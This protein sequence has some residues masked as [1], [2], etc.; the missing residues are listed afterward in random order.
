MFYFTLLSNFIF[1][2][3]KYEKTYDKKRL[4]NKTFSNQFFLLYENELLIGYEKAKKILEKH[5]KENDE[6]ICLEAETNLKL[7]NNHKS[8]VG[9]YIKS[10]KIKINNVYLTKINN[11]VVLLEKI[12]IEDLTSKSYMINTT[13]KNVKNLKPRSVSI[14]P[15]A[16][17]CQAKCSFCF[18]K[19]SAS[20]DIHNKSLDFDLINNLLLKS[21]NNGATRA[22]ITGGGE[23]TMLKDDELLKLIKLMSSHFKTLLMITNSYKYTLMSKDEIYLKLKELKSNGLTRIGVSRH[24]YCLEKNTKLMNLKIESEKILEVYR[25]CENKEELPEIRLICVIQKNGIST[26]SDV[27]KYIKWGKQY[28]IK[29]FCFKELYVSSTNES[30]Y[31]S[32]ENND[33]SYE[34]QIPLKVVID[35]CK[36]KNL[37][38]KG[39]LPWGTPVYGNDDLSIACYT[40]PSIGWEL[41]NNMCRSWNI[42]SDGKCLASLEHLDS[43]IL[44]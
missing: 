11:N 7:F 41:N 8:G 32:Y 39:K 35:T 33:W 28:K 38:I 25:D 3:D 5:G 10:S 23:P 30:E 24:H 27:K 40:E 21:K 20:T 43:E 16:I 13:E 15:I 17:G 4:K 18:S 2:F 29:E 31:S 1:G 14:L 6:I 22:V 19:Y 9:Q 44:V 34:N 37:T 26:K 36:E 42:M 12:R